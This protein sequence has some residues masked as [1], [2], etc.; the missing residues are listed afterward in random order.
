VAVTPPPYPATHAPYTPD[1]PKEEPLKPPYLRHYHKG[2]TDLYYV[3]STHE[4]RIE[5]DTF[6]T[7]AK[8]IDKYKPDIVVVE[9]L[10]S[11]ASRQYLQG[12]RGGKETAT[13]L[14]LDSV[15]RGQN[16]SSQF[17]P[18]QSN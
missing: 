14:R 5:T 2:E 3:T 4:C 12:Y 18:M 17:R 8:A 6:K 7:V 1:L 15:A 16:N 11:S 10:E 13:Q 9:G